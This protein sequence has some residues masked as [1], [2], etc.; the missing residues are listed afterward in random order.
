MKL[1]FTASSISSIAISRM[2]RFL[3]LRKMPTTLIANRIAPEHEVVR[4]RRL[5][6]VMH[7]DPLRVGELRGHDSTL[8]RLP[9]FGGHRARC[10]ARSSRRTRTC[11]AGS[12]YLVSLRC[13]SVSAIAAMIATS[14][15]TAAISNG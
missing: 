2:I 6:S 14:R 7:V 9:L 1:M 10:A 5:R 3:R 11:S 4:Q 12:W 8:A 15:I 13:R